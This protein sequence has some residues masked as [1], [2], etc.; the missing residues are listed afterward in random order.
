MTQSAGWPDVVLWRV[1]PSDPQPE[2][3]RNPHETGETE[4]YRPSSHSDVLVEALEEIAEG[5]RRTGHMIGFEAQRGIARN[6]L[7]QYRAG[8]GS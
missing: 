2:V 7:D 5:R 4:T 1:G 3:A 8:G 6:A